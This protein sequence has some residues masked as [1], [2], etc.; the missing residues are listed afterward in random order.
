MKPGPKE[1]PIEQAKRDGTPA[2]RVP[3]PPLRT[4]VGASIEMP[5]YFNKFQQ[6]AWNELMTMLSDLNVLDSADA[7][8]LENAA[9]MLGRTREARHEL[10]HS[11]MVVYTQ[12]GAAIPSPWWKIE[13]EA[14]LQVSRL[15]AELGLSPSA[16]ARLA[17]L[18]AK[19]KTPEEKIGDLLGAPGR[20]RLVEGGGK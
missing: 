2:A 8:T 1:K 5:E 16:R 13:R 17:N 15:L 9:A 18:G 6:K 14:S 12:R 20:L 11:D 4:G 3:N 10:N 19:S 7:A